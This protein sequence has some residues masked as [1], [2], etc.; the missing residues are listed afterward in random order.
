MT[1]LKSSHARDCCGNQLVRLHEYHCDP[2]N[3]MNFTNHQVLSLSAEEVAN[4]FSTAFR[5]DE[6]AAEKGFKIW[7]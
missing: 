7:V 5:L 2:I 3:S 4:E 6:I 1:L